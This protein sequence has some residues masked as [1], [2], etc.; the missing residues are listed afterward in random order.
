MLEVDSGMQFDVHAEYEYRRDGVL[1]EGAEDLPAFP[2]SSKN[3]RA[4]RH[5]YRRGLELPIAY[6]PNGAADSMIAVTAQHEPRDAGVLLAVVL[7]LVGIGLA[8][9][10]AGAFRGFLASA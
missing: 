3:A 10:A 7:F 1:Q 4:L 6:D 9:L 5:A 2:I 8:L